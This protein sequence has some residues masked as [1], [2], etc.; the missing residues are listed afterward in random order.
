MVMIIIT[1]YGG[2]LGSYD[3]F[4]WLLYVGQKDPE[5]R[6][7]PLHLTV[8]RATLRYGASYTSGGE[9]QGY[10]RPFKGIVCG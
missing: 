4:S 3:T 7:L 6:I 2:S 1:L 9:F 10:V 8:F 5:T